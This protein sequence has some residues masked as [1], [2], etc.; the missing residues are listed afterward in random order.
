MGPARVKGRFPDEEVNKNTAYHEAGHALVALYTQHAT[1][2]HKV[3]IIPRGP[4]MGHT[5]FLPDKESYQV[6]RAQL[7]AQLDV[8]MGG[9]VAEEMIFGDD[10]VTTGAAQD[11]KNATQVA[12]NMVRQFG[13]SEKLGLRDFSV[14]GENNSLIT[15]NELSPQTNELIDQEIARLLK[16]SYDR[17]KTILTD[18][19]KEH[20][21]LAEALLHY[22]TLSSDEIRQLLKT[23]KIERPNLTDP[24]VV[25]EIIP[26]Q[27]DKKRRHGKHPPIIHVNVD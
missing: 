24:I 26:R 27:G 19:S 21:M 10:F 16:E 2:V 22:E 15:V 6:S 20:H 5:A 4:S 8:M 23:G 17:A 18:K 11:L 1:P 3:T 14:T 12:T 7:L 13:L 9:R 25:T